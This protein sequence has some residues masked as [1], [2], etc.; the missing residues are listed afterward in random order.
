MKRSTDMY[1]R[2]PDLAG[3]TAVVT[4]GSRGIGAE[5]ARALAANG[6]GVVVNGRD[7]AALDAVVASIASA[8]RRAPA[9][10]S[11]RAVLRPNLD[12]RAVR[13]GTGRA[14]AGGNDVAGAVALHPGQR[15]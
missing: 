6:V 11:G 8:R 14:G 7:Q 2:Y 13:G 1:T 5:T 15:P 9:P 4:G 10:Y 12:H 3:R